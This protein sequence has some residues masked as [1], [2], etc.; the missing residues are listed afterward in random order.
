MAGLAIVDDKQG[1]CVKPGTGIWQ[2]ISGEQQQSVTGKL[3]AWKRCECA[4]SFRQRSCKE[5]A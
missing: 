4:C 2:V 1:L 3:T 5:A